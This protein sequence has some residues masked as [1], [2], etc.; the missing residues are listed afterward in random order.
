M[1]AHDRQVSGAAVEEARSRTRS[2]SHS[3]RPPIHVLARI[4]F[5]SRVTG[6]PSSGRPTRV[7]NTKSLQPLERSSGSSANAR[8]RSSRRRG[9]PL[10]TDNRGQPVASRR[11]R[12]KRSQRFLTA[13]SAVAAA[14]PFSRRGRI[15]GHC[16]PS[17]RALAHDRLRLERRLATLE[18]QSQA[19]RLIYVGHLHENRPILRTGRVRPDVVAIQPWALES[20]GRLLTA[21]QV[22]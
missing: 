1:E 3:S 20:L 6:V 5:K 9:A 8:A 14:V 2:C 4:R 18:C 19:A 11:S 13:Q 15:N 22:F 17:C 21:T 12:S 16:R 10:C 7:V